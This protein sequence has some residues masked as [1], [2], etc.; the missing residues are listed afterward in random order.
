[1]ANRNIFCPYAKIS[2][3]IKFLLLIVFLLFIFSSTIIYACYNS[4]NR[5]CDQVQVVANIYGIPSDPLRSPGTGS[6][7]G[8]VSSSLSCNCVY[9]LI[10]AEYLTDYG[11]YDTTYGYNVLEAS[12]YSPQGLTGDWVETYSRSFCSG[13]KAAVIAF[14]EGYC[15]T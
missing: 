4:D 8:A 14:L 5:I 12:F 10:I 6:A 1:M 13:A 3:R 15:G 2:T 9:S 7:Y 11:C